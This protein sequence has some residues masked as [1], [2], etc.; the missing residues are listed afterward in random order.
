MGVYLHMPPEGSARIL[1]DPYQ[2]KQQGY[3]ED[4]EDYTT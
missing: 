3:L 2:P 4:G 1:S